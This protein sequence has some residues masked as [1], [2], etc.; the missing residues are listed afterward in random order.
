MRLWLK[1]RFMKRKFGIKMAHFAFYV[2]FFYVTFES[3]EKKKSSL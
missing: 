3:R 1:K 2:Y